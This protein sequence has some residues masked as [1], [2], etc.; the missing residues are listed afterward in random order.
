MPDFQEMDLPDSSRDSMID[1]HMHSSASDGSDTPSELAEKCS[2]AGLKAAALSDHDTVSGVPEF[3]EA[4]KKY[5]FEAIPGVEISTRLYD[6]ELHMI[7]LFIDPTSGELEKALS[8]L[9]NGRLERN[10][11]IIQKLRFAGYNIAEEDVFKA[12]KGE[13]VG[14]PHIAQILV[15]KGYFKSVQ[16][17][18]CTCLKKGAKFYVPRYYLNPSESIRVIHESGG[19]AIWAHPLHGARGERAYLRKFIRK[20]QPCGLDGME[21]Y[22]SSFTGEQ[23]RLALSQAAEFGLLCSGGSDYHGKNRPGTELG[24]GGGNLH[25]P[26]ALV[27]KMHHFMRLRKGQ[28]EPEESETGKRSL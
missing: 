26:Y 11:L 5:A 2:R 4:A 25:V 24:T 23:Q 19:I 10:H 18:F 14:R 8:K 1:L 12:A 13:S 9:R 7:G 22:Y 21:T 15:A 20:L 17:V 27:E 28:A 3:L 6:K 16:D